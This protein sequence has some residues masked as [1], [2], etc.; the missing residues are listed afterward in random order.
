MAGAPKAFQ[1]TDLQALKSVWFKD[2]PI[3]LSEILRK[4]NTDVILP[5]TMAIWGY[6]Q[7]PN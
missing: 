7:T 2:C 3:R 1:V 4:S 5:M 6:F